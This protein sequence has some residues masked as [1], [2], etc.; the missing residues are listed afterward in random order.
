MITNKSRERFIPTA[1]K[2]FEMQTYK[3]KK[4]IVLNHSYGT[5]LVK[6]DATANVHE[7]I[8]NKEQQN[9]SLGKLRNIALKAFVPIGGLWTPFD[10]DDWHRS[11]FLEEFQKR[12]EYNHLDLLFLK[13]RLEYNMNNGFIFKSKFLN[14]WAFF[15]AKR[16]EDDISQELYDDLDTLEDAHIGERYMKCGKKVGKFEND[17]KIY[18]RMIHTTNSSIFVR[19]EKSTI[20][21]YGSMNNYQE[22]EA[23]DNEKAYVNHVVEKYFV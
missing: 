15:L 13:N 10:D 21:E 16:I 9:F 8:V 7:Y 22:F 12:L 1:I 18:I 19:K 5:K 3:D 11:D 20:Q 23:S 6:A 17:P 14:G 2:N 4:L